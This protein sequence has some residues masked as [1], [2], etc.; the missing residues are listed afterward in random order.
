MRPVLIGNASGFWGDDIAAPLRLVQQCP[1]L[2]YLTLDYLAELSLSIMAIQREHDPTAGY[3]RDF[4]GVVQSLAPLWRQGRTF[5]LVA[6][7]G[8][9]NPLGCAQACLEVLQAAGC[10]GLRIGVITGDDILPLMQ[11]DSASQYENL[12]TREPISGVRD[13]LVTANA[14]LGCQP[15]VEALQSGAQL[16]ISGRVADPSLTVAPCAFHHGWSLSDYSRL[17]GATV[18][19]HLI[20]CGTQVTGGIST[21]W[22]EMPDPAHIGF[23]IAEVDEQGDCIITK[24]P[25]TGG[26]VNEETVKEQLLY[27]IGDP[28][29][30]LSP[31]ATVSFMALS[32]EE[33]EIDRV[34]VAGA[35][36]S[37]PP[38]TYKVSAC[39]RDGYRSE[40]QLIVVGPDAPAKAKRCGEIILQRVRDAGYDL[41]RS[42]IECLGTGDVAPGFS[43][44]LGLR[45]LV[46]RICV[47]DQRREAVE[48]FTKELAPLVTSGPPGITGYATGRPHVRPV[49]GYWPC[50]V[51]CDRVTPRVSILEVP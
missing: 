16:V 38:P 36:G 10:H 26:R 13:R 51:G 21:R 25:G 46:L 7:A 8:G 14:Y 9:L 44:R 28:A 40:G 6:N 22:L 42:L 32:V 15:I 23:P 2:D 31:D 45:E 41:E 4:V 35:L 20:E 47:A 5:K 34:R 39:Y 24:P 37:A 19:G 48:R 43:P 1:T 27:E 29:N 50:L 49:F 33:K 12:E 17:A 30:Y 3:A 11:D 18:A